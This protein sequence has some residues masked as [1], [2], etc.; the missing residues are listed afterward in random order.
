MDRI[1]DSTEVTAETPTAEAG[2]SDRC[3]DQFPIRD[4]ALIGD[5]HGCALVSRSGTI[6]WCVFQRFDAA[7]ALCRLL[8]ARK[9]GFLSTT[10]SGPYGAKRGY[11]DGTNILRTT[12]LCPRG[13]ASITDYMPVGRRRGA[14]MHDYTTLVAPHLL[15]RT[16]E[17][18]QGEVTLDLAFRPSLDYARRP[19]RLVASPRGVFAEHGPALHAALAFSIDGDLT[20]SRIRL[21]AGQR[22]AVILAA[23]PLA[24]SLS[25]QAVAKLFDITCAFW[26][27]W[28][29]YCRYDGPYRDMVRRSALTLKLLTYAPTGAI[30]AAATTSLPEH[31]GGER[32]WD[33]RFCWLRDASFTL[34]ALAVLGYSGEAAAFGRFLKLVCSRRPKQIQIMYGIGG[35]MEL[36][37]EI[38]EH[39]EGYC[40]SRPVRI[41]NAAYEQRQTD[42]YGELLD[43]IHVMTALGR[44]LDADDRALLEQMLEFVTAH[45]D[46]PDQGLWE[47]RDVPRHYVY[48]KMMSWVALDRGLR[49][50]GERSDW[51]AFRD[52][53]RAEILERGVAQGHLVQAYDTLHTDAALLLTPMLGFPIDRDTLE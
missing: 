31:V 12:F 26:R 38:L 13:V 35:E 7:P 45:A 21:V 24:E 36:G 10:P 19:A 28:I 5:C 9:G 6:D 44:R 3:S 50:V 11:L 25:D 53:L 14:D 32:N 16:I 52:R 29:A 18:V 43:W 41:G 1:F 33:Y 17:G 39:L 49:L 4:Y 48:G 15:I 37:E 2:M 30:V 8:D 46:E 34:Y 42:I 20:Q 27:E 51:Q 22:Q 23:M 40:G 47:A